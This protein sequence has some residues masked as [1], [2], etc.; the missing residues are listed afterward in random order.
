MVKG[1]RGMRIRIY[2]LHMVG[3]GDQSLY[4]NIREQGEEMVEPSDSKT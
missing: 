1:N 2:S 3:N 4:T